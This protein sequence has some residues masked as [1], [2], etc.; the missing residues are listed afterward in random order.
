MDW[1]DWGTALEVLYHQA[2]LNC[3]ACFPELLIL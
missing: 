3:F 2:C 1:E